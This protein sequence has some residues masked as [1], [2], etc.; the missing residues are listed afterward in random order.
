[1]RRREAGGG[2][3]VPVFLE[4]GRGNSHTARPPASKIWAASPHPT[5]G[6]GFQLPVLLTGHFPFSGCLSREPPYTGPGGLRHGAISALVSVGT[7][8]L[9]GPPS[10]VC[11]PGP[12][13][14]CRH[15]QPALF[16]PN[17]CHVPFPTLHPPCL[18]FCSLT[19]QNARSNFSWIWPEN[20]HPSQPRLWKENETHKPSSRSLPARRRAA[21][22]PSP[23]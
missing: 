16:L 10:K 12:A 5:G 20:T 13:P 7:A 18:A 3:L 14:E 23:E 21:L 22:P 4:E 15:L 6:L 17:S 1:M 2:P 9:A 19:L 11:P 8:P